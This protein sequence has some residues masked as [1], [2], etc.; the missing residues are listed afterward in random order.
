MNR[1]ELGRPWLEDRSARP[2]AVRLSAR[3]L[4]GLGLLALIGVLAVAGLM[5]GSRVGSP[6]DGRDPSAAGFAQGA[7][8]G[9]DR[10]AAAAPPAAGSLDSGLGGFV[11]VAA[12]GMLVLALLLLTL[13]LIGHLSSARGGATAHLHVLES[14][15]LAQRAS[16][17][18]VAIGDRRLVVGLTPG[19][20]VAL[21]ELAADELPGLAADDGPVL[22]APGIDPS[23]RGPIGPF[24]RVVADLGRRIGSAR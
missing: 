7:P 5:G 4:A 9:E 21:A 14:R 22:T 18:L 23:G 11:D 12:K 16:L 24:A 15:P 8:V 20:L 1:P 6:R 17:H 3:T 13:R 10:P 2:G 19:G